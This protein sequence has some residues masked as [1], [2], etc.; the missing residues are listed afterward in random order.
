MTAIL[1]GHRLA[2]VAELR[3]VRRGVRMEAE[4]STADVVLDQVAVMDNLRVV[5]KFDEVEI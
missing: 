2:P 1:R 4:G 3:T 5:S